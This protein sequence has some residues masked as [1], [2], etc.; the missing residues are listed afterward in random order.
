[1]PPPHV[2]HQADCPDCGATFNYCGPFYDERGLAHPRRCRYCRRARQAA[3]D[4]AGPRG[5]DR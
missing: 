5:A 4:G 3:K 2:T 1:M